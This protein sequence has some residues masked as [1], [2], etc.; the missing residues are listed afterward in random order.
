MLSF[1]Y[2]TDK[3]WEAKNEKPAEKVNRSGTCLVIGGTF[4]VRKIRSTASSYE[5]FKIGCD[6]IGIHLV[7]PKG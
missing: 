7:Y 2:S 6:L 5:M 1:L 3:I 4:E